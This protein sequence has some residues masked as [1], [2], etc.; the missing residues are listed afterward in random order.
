M[1][2]SSSQRKALRPWW[3]GKACP[4]EGEAIRG[5]LRRRQVAKQLRLYEGCGKEGLWGL[6]ERGLHGDVRPMPISSGRS[7]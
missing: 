3:S 4:P 1:S 5:R 2:V 6:G 7:W